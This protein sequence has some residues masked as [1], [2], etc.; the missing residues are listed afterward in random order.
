MTAKTPTTTSKASQKKICRTATC[1]Q[2]PTHVTGSSTIEMN[3]FTSC[4]TKFESAILRV[5]LRLVLSTMHM[6]R[7][8]N[9]SSSTLT[10]STNANHMNNMHY[11][12][13]CYICTNREI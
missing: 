2:T 11:H 9:N 8:R 4:E 13:T 5:L 7:L 1:T 12:C 3:K 6:M 10:C